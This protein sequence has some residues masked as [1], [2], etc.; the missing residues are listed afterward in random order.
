MKRLLSMYLLALVL[1]AGCTIEDYTPK[2][3]NPSYHADQVI[4]V[5][6]ADSPTCPIFANQPLILD[7]ISYSWSVEYTGSGRW[8]VNK[9]CSGGTAIAE[10]THQAYFY[11]VT[12][13]IV[14]LD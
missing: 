12:G 9:V 5:A 4:S 1:L 3:D 11:E 2:I 14:W 10:H 6:Q 7:K 13:Q 8:L